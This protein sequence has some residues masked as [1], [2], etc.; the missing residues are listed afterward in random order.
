[1]RVLLGRVFSAVGSSFLSLQVITPFLC[2][3]FVILPLLGI[4][5]LFLPLIFVSWITMRPGV[6]LLG[7]ILPEALCASWTC[8]TIC[9]PMLRKFS[10]FIPSNIF[11]ASFSLSSPCGTPIL[12]M[13]FCLMLSQSSLECLHSFHSFFYILFCSSDFY[14]SIL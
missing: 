11:L 2:T 9:F 1:M 13:L 12:L 5:I 4:N 8:L 7:F 3:L 6:F 14:H 10:A